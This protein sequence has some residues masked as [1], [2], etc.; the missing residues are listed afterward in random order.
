MLVIFTRY[1]VPG[2]AKTRLIPAIGAEHAAQLQRHMTQQTI[3]MAKACQVPLQIRFYGG[4]PAQMQS[5]LGDDLDYQPQG[6]GDL[7]AKMHNAFQ[8][9][10]KQGHDRV[11]IIGTDCPF[12]DRKLIHQA[13]EHLNT[14]DLVLGPATDGGYY[15]IGLRKLFPELFESI[16]WSTNTVRSKT[17]AIAQANNISYALLPE[18]SDIDL[19]EDLAKLPPHLKTLLNNAPQTYLPQNWGA[20]GTPPELG[21]RGPA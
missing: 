20:G 12:I 10:F 1:P 21:G 18:L 16:T 3:T 8:K 11:V 19:P 5:W 15:L 4:T 17:I 6:E 2:Q 14:H 13:F 9:G 7:G